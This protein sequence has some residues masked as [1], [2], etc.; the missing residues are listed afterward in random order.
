MTAFQGHL[1]RQR[2]SR[3]RCMRMCVDGPS[4]ELTVCMGLFLCSYVF[5]ISMIHTTMP[6]LT[7]KVLEAN[8][9]R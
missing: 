7:T 1:F 6:C 9:L 2:G 3:A 8:R 5:T 4:R